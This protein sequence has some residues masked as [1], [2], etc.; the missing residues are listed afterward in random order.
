[1]DFKNA[2]EIIE[3]F[4]KKPITTLCILAGLVI[5]FIALMYFG[6]FFG[7][8][9]KQLAGPAQEIRGVSP[10]P[11]VEQRQIESPNQTSEKRSEVSSP[12]KTVKQ[13]TKKSK[14]PD[15]KQESGSHPRAGESPTVIQQTEG[16]QSPAVYVA[17]GGKSTIT[18]SA[19]KENKGKE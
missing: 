19:P 17:P 5:L 4:N 15:I 18:Y 2:K 9:G 8:K 11:K 7:E 14:E 12:S 16:D 13:E 10:P 6:G 3:S 1:M